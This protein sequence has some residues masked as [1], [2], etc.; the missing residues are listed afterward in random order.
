AR[1]HH[2]LLAAP[3]AQRRRTGLTT[4]PD[5]LAQHLPRTPPWPLP[6]AEPAHSPPSSHDR[7]TLPSRTSLVICVKCY[8]FIRLWR[9]PPPD[10][11]RELD[12]ESTPADLRRSTGTGPR[13]DVRL[14]TD[15]N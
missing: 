4:R 5:L 9:G 2:L 7:S 3:P 1:A 6:P 11:G 14:G 10:N 15:R 13:N 12:D 8:L